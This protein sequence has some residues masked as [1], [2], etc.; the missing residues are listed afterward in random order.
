MTR[1][2]GEH[3]Q[4]PPIVLTKERQDGRGSARGHDQSPSCREHLL[5]VAG[6]ERGSVSSVAAVGEMSSHIAA[7]LADR[8][9]RRAVG[10]VVGG[11]NP[12]GR[13]SLLHVAVPSAS[14]R[15]VIPFTAAIGTTHL[16]IPKRNSCCNGHRVLRRG[17]VH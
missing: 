1:D 11:G 8:I 9:A 3:P 13:L 2:I 12:F 5:Y 10:L 16:R 15:Q 6:D 7:V 4:C 17:A 14:T